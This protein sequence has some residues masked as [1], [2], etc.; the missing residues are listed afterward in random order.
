MA[1]PTK[2]WPGLAN[3]RLNR[4]GLKAG[5]P[6]PDFRLP[7]VDGGELSLVEYRG[8]R[9][10]LVFSDP[11]CGPCEQLA[12]DL[13]RLHRQRS[14]LAVLMVSR[15]DEAAN[16]QKVAALGLT[17]PVA[18]QQSWEISLLY[19][20][21]ATPIGYLIDEQGVIAADMAKGVGPILALVSGAEAPT[22]GAL[23]HRK[24]VAAL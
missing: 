12:P 15:R 4:S 5:T 24:E 16:R 10:L 1:R 21:F 23:H 11:E 6:A 14:D 20:I 9:V 7:R 18:L 8:R 3:S 17:F 19:G 2:G 22:N 13:E